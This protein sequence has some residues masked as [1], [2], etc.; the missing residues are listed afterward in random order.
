[1]KSLPADW[2]ANDE[3]FQLEQD[4]IFSK[5]WSLVAHAGQVE[6]PGSFVTAVIAGI[7]VIVLKSLEHEIKAF[8]NICRHRAA[9]LCTR[10]T[11]KTTRFTCP[12]HA[13]SYDLDGNLLSAPGVELGRDID[14]S[15][16][17][18]IP[19]R[20]SIWNSLIFACLD[21]DCVTLSDWLGEIVSI[22]GGYPP[23][24]G[25]E[26]AC[27]RL[28][29]CGI[30]W[31]N[32]SD[33]SAEGYHL[34]R[35]HPELNESLATR[36]T[37]IRV[38]ENGQFV[39]FEI[40]YKQGE[41]TAPGHWVY[42]YPGLLMHFSLSSFNVEKVTPLSSTRTRMQRWFWFGPSVGERQRE[43]VV[44]LSDQV[45]QQDMSICRHV[46]KNLES[47]WFQDSM[48]FHDREPGTIYFQ[49]CVREALGE[50]GDRL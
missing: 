8:V 9:P 33:N 44:S 46:Q 14:A 48:L 18:L 29:E 24:S 30:N 17:G 49:Q 32:Y 35:V 10:E 4:R 34:S 43:E 21:K 39:G 20:V 37:R 2:Y 13:W 45:I 1:M 41:S 28:N 25:M 3:I 12:Y 26:Y 38:H 19:V 5:N 36:Q 15:K 31:K 47:G 40:T 50:H 23:L 7:S 6:K 42:K 16:F 27:T 11:G 22:A